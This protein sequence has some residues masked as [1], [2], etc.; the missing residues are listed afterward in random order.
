MCD[1]PSIFTYLAKQ[2][3]PPAIHLRLELRN[4]IFSQ[5]SAFSFDV[6]TKKVFMCVKLKSLV[7]REAKVY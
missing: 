5:I 7:D 4:M 1:L 6:L 3:A 2:Q